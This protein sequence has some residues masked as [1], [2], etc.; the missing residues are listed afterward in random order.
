MIHLAKD[1][2]LT[3]WCGGD[4]KAT[5]CTTAE[6]NLADCDDCLLSALDYA[7][8][9]RERRGELLAA[10]EAPA[11]ECRPGAHPARE[12]YLKG[13]AERDGAICKLGWPL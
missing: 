1:D 3:P 6:V 9:V 10:K 12:N 7:E 13:A 2:H 8:L 5:D 11:C 4:E